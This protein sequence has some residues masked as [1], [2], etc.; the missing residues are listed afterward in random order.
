MNS[1]ILRKQLEK[2]RPL[3]P[4]PSRDDHVPQS[5]VDD[6]SYERFYTLKDRN[7]DLS[8]IK[9]YLP[10]LPFH[11]MPQWMSF[12]TTFVCNLRC[13]HCETHGT[14][15]LHRFY[16]S[17]KLDMPYETLSRVAKQSLPWADE[18][19]LTMSGEPL[20]TPDLQRTLRELGQYGA[21]LDLTTN[22]TYFSKETLLQLI[23]MTS[24]IQISIDGATQLTCE[25]IRLGVKFKKLLGNIRLLTRTLELLPEAMRPPVCIS[26][27]IMGSNLRDLPELV[28]MASALGIQAVHGHF[29]IVNELVHVRNEVVEKH[30]PIYNAYYQRAHA[31]AEKM[32]VILII[33][34]PFPE[35][36]GDAAAPVGGEGMIIN[37]LSENYYETLLAPESW[38][39]HAAIETEASEIASRLVSEIPAPAG[40]LDGQDGALPDGAFIRDKSFEFLEW[41]QDIYKEMLRHNGQKIKYCDMLHKRMYISPGGDVTPCCV[42]GTSVLGNVN[43]NTVEEI[44]NGEPYKEF[45]RRFRSSDPVDCCKNCIHVQY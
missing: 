1:Q 44:W 28:R 45:R 20:A 2:I 32:G 30:K 39:D 21:K 10:D 42:F 27:T 43:D 41:C 34:P 3:P 4:L 16:N 23:P 29:V 38:L 6:D 31:L 25:A 15:E 5:E 33:P 24:K 22:G 14:P 35:I 17:K 40:A 37:H 26:F 18:F 9:M 11:T 13:P 8:E 12:L 19:C 36:E 7:K